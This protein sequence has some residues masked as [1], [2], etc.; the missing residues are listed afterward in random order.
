MSEGLQPRVRWSGER[1]PRAF[2]ARRAGSSEI[3]V[4][5]V[6]YADDLATC[7]V[8]ERASALPA[9]VAHVAGC[10]VDALLNH[11]VRILHPRRRR[12]C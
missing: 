10:A 12:H 11:C 5:D 6:V 1:Q 3:A 4:Q 2:D 9:A 8:A 7:V